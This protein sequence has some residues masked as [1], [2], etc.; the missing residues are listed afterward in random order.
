M[1]QLKFLGIGILFGVILTKSEAVS[2]YRIYEMFRFESFHMYGII[3]TAV[4]V[5]MIFMFLFKKGII[6]DYLGKQIVLKDK[7][8]GIIR[9]LVGGTLFG[10]GWAL[11]GAC[12][13]PIFVLI[14]HGIFPILIVLAGAIL[15]AFV[16]GMVSKKLPN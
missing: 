14:G 4:G 2:W 7:K 8:K 13:A 9:T 15:G 11:A 12:P 10:L 6:K 3:G 1:K 5:S 16:Y